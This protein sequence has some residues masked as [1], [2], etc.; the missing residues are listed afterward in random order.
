MKWYLIQ[1]SRNWWLVAS[2]TPPD[3]EV[4]MRVKRKKLRGT[5][6]DEATAKAQGKALCAHEMGNWV[7]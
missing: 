7:E 4:P 3:L 2:S 6:T 1:Q 5:F